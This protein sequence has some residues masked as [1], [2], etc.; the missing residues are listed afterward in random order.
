MS[1]LLDE[2]EDIV[3]MAAPDVLSD[4]EEKNRKRRIFRRKKKKKK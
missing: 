1:A 4:F 2:A 3:N